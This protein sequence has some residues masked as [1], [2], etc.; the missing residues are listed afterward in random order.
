MDIF[1]AKFLVQTLRE[2]AKRKLGR[3]KRR[4]GRVAA[5]RSG[6]TCEEERA[7]LA[8]FVEGLPLERCDSLTR[9]RKRGLDVRVGRS[10]QF[11]LRDL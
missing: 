11:L 7:S 6:R 3:R 2:R 10:V 1:L 8:A 9:K 5:Q 4:R